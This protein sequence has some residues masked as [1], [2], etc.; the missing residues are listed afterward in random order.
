M[1]GNRQQEERPA[2]LAGELTGWFSFLPRIRKFFSIDTFKDIL[3]FLGLLAIGLIVITA[4][5][6][7]F[8]T[9]NFMLGA[10]IF[11]TSALTV[12]TVISLVRA[13]NSPLSRAYGGELSKLGFSLED[14]EATP[15]EKAHQLFSIKNIKSY[16][17]ADL[18]Q[19]LISDEELP[20]LSKEPTYSVRIKVPA[21]RPMSELE[22]ALSDLSNLN[23]QNYIQ[24]TRTENGQEV[25]VTD[26]EEKRRVL[27]SIDNEFKLIMNGDGSVVQS[28]DPWIKRAVITEALNKGGGII[29]RYCAVVRNELE[30]KCLLEKI[31][32]TANIKNAQSDFW[33]R[34]GLQSIANYTWYALLGLTTFGFITAAF[35]GLLPVFATGIVKTISSWPLIKLSIGGLVTSSVVSRFLSVFTGSVKASE[36]AIKAAQYFKD[37]KTNELEKEFVDVK[38]MIGKIR[39]LSQEGRLNLRGAKGGFIMDG[40]AYAI[41]DLLRS[42]VAASWRVLDLSN[43][44]ISSDGAEKIAASLK[45]TGN[46]LKEINLSGNITHKGNWQKTMATFVEALEKNCTLTKLSYGF[47]VWAKVDRR[48]LKRIEEQLLINRFIANPQSDEFKPV[49]GFRSFLRSLMGAKQPTFERLQQVAIDK[50]VEIPFLV[51]LEEERFYGLEAFRERVMAAQNEYPEKRLALETEFAE[52]LEKLS[53]KRKSDP[54]YIGRHAPRQGGKQVLMG[55]SNSHVAPRVHR[56]RYMALPLR[57]DQQHSARLSQKAG[58]EAGFLGT[59]FSRARSLVLGHPANSSRQVGSGSSPSRPTDFDLSEIFGTSANEKLSAANRGPCTD[60][61]ERG[62]ARAEGLGVHTN[63]ASPS[64]PNL[65]IAIQEER[66][67]HEAADLSEIPEV[68]SGLATAGDE[69]APSVSLA[70]IS[71]TSISSE[72]NSRGSSPT[73]QSHE[74]LLPSANVPESMQSPE[75]LLPSANVPESINYPGFFPGPH[76]RLRQREHQRDRHHRRR[77]AVLAQGGKAASKGSK[78]ASLLARGLSETL[79]P[80]QSVPPAVPIPNV[81]TKESFFV[82]DLVGL[83]RRIL[84]SPV[85]KLIPGLGMDKPKRD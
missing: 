68:D 38:K 67:E 85:Q 11:F 22:F 35:P 18:K 61:T 1:F 78:A 24:V 70:D 13:K 60:T 81:K 51:S 43:N 41:A 73:R 37:K 10:T 4:G 25:S 6:F 46:V 47:Y 26:E 56:P 53:S 20:D 69:N 27:A 32:H 54:F 17:L 45:V 29:D 16:D 48:T 44:Y 9:G 36:K 3:L 59:L 80:Q 34:P 65:R 76:Q 12:S 30:K 40:S 58:Q 55:M 84:P 66:K 21:D 8:V 14:K 19:K 72:A 82:K 31:N 77:E 2:D 33:Y 57:P 71:S 23:D 64:R 83:L 39:N 74:K 49:S 42:P 79:S 7:S 62:L 75:E 50:L 52:G 63:A 5:V 28:T 15:A